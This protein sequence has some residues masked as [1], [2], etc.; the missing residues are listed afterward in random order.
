M[1]EK[2]LI[3]VIVPVYNA[4]DCL[5]ECLKS[6]QKQTYGNLQ[7]I[8]VDDGSTD[9][10]A[11][12]CDEFAKEDSRII[13]IHQKN[14]GAATARKNAMQKASGEYVCFVDADDKI[15]DG[16]IEFLADSIGECDL[17]T[18]GCYC[19][20]SQGQYAIRTDSLE[21]KIY[22]NSNEMKY[23]ISNM[24]VFEGRYDAGVL[25]FLWNKMYKTAL[26]RE[27]F[28]DIDPT[29][30]YGEDWDFLFRYILKAKSIRVTYKSFYYYRY[31]KNSV[32]RKTNDMFMSDL[33]RLYLSLKKVFEQHPLKEN[34]MYQLQLFITSRISRIT[35]NMGFIPAAQLTKYACPFPEL[36]KDS[37]IILYGAG[38][39][40]TD[41]Y[42]QIYRRKLAELV[43]WV[44][45]RWMEYQNDYTPVYAPEEITNHVYDYIIIAVTK[46]ELAD[47]IR[48][49]LI[50]KE[51]AEEKILWRM[52]VIATV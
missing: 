46:K 48:K 37:K 50:Q 34:L 23:F 15:D 36:E 51:I 18:S 14:M 43:L 40:G 25:P 35:Y 31:K 11:K 22:H 19:E 16:F 13:I 9:N 49:E 12:I 4:D 3:S 39:V 42:W 41:Y 1:N 52:P 21:E 24:V 6:I 32:S 29:I 47:E 28:D 44:D 30:L 5:E 8:V 26:V 17:I 2:A 33:N 7:I 10:S 20:N 27:T 45:K 38:K